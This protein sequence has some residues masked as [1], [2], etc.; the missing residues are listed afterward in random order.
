MSQ[1]FPL[2]NT[3]ETIPIEPGISLNSQ[4]GRHALLATLSLIHDHESGVRPLPKE[5]LG[6]VQTTYE[7]L[8]DGNWGQGGA[9]YFRPITPDRNQELLE[10]IRL[11]LFNDLRARGFSFSAS[12]RMK[13]YSDVMVKN[14]IEIMVVPF[15]QGLRVNAYISLRPEIIGDR[16]FKDASGELPKIDF[17]DLPM[18]AQ[19]FNYGMEF[20]PELYI[21]HD[22]RNYDEIWGKVLAAIESASAVTTHHPDKFFV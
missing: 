17:F 18:T 4:L 8:L 12:S 16:D 21:R 20:G 11:R 14:G 9:F 13:G 19:S 15:P 7:R 10:A 3:T 22:G 5:D 1:E 6:Q 2:R